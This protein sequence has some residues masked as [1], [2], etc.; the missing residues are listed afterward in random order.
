MAAVNEERLSRRK[1]EIA[2]PHRSINACLESAGV[3]AQDVDLVAGSTTDIAKTASR[4]RPASKERY[5][6]IRRQQAARALSNNLR[7]LAK[8]WITEW[9]GNAVTHGLSER[10]IRRELGRAGLSETPL[11]MFDHHQCHIAAAAL[12][13][14]FNPSLAF[15][16]DGVGDGLSASIALFDGVLLKR[17]ATTPARYSLGIFFEHVTNLMNMRELEDEGKVMAMADYADPVPDSDN[18]MLNLIWVDGLQ[19]YSRVPTRSMRPALQRILTRYSYEQFAWMAQRTVEVCI[20]RLVK[21][22]VA[23]TGVGNVALA[24]GVAANVKAN[25]LVAHLPGVDQIYVFPHMGDGGLAAGAAW[26]AGLESAEPQPTP[27]TSVGLGKEYGLRDIRASLTQAGMEWQEPSNLAE[28]CAN[29]LAQGRVVLLFQGK[30]EY[31]PRALGNRSILA[32]ADDP[33]IR[34]RLNHV[35]KRRA[36]FQPFCPSMLSSFAQGALEPMTGQANRFMT[37]AYRV[38]D[39]AQPALAG[40]VSVD[41][42]CRPQ[43]VDDDCDNMLGTILRAL[44]ARGEKPVVLNTSFNIH[45][46]PLVETPAEAI[47]VFVRSGADALAIG[48]YLVERANP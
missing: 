6:Q 35:L 39:S 16:I 14:G 48:P 46:E 42:T 22:A 26:L 47:D 18:P 33:A 24:G 11:R 12:G 9:P 30:S 15:S 28:R 4:L 31:G 44:Q 21:N 34:D 41:H 40:V 23:E 36:W 7:K 19:F 32:R 20:T 17:I 10:A 45:G 43:F 37:L 38:L 27:L 2:F 3:T 25:R 8:Y 5:Y 1:L 13:S 29:L